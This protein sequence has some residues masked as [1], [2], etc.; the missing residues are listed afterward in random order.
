MQ[1]IAERQEHTSGLE[2]D[3]GISNDVPGGLKQLDETS[4]EEIEIVPE[5]PGNITTEHH[6]EI[7]KSKYDGLHGMTSWKW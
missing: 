7:T 3:N 1:K 5:K 4:G 6:K 2:K